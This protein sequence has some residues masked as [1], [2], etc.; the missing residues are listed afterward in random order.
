MNIYLEG[1]NHLRIP[2]KGFLRRAVGNDIDLDVRPCRDRDRTIRLFGQTPSSDPLLLIDSDGADLNALRQD[3]L[4]RAN[5][6]NA[7]ERSFFMV[8]LMEAWFL[9]D[10]ECLASYY[11]A[12]FRGG[13][14]PGNQPEDVTKNDV[15]DRL[16]QA[17]QDTSK[18][19][20]HKTDHA[21]ELLG[22]LNPTTVYS[23]CPNFALLIDH[24]RE[25]AAA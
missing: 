24:L 12:S 13:R 15:M 9:A 19:A 16:R 18:G 25:H 3:V 6:A 5:V 23:A 7:R 2:M 20:Y 14:L 22:R 17:T 4:T 10:R 1:G 11:G 8:Q 21:P